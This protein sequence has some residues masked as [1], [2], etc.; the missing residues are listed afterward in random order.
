MVTRRNS[1][2]ASPDSSA[3]RS[4]LSFSSSCQNEPYCQSKS[5]RMVSSADRSASSCVPACVISRI[6]VE[7]AS[8]SW[9]AFSCRTVSCRRASASE[10][11]WPTRADSAARRPTSETGS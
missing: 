8:T 6:T 7:T 4:T 10:T 5:L 2:P 11:N 9:A 3:K 1:A